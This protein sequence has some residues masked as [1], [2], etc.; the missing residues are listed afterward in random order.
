MPHP[1]ALDNNTIWYSPTQ[2][3][4]PDFYANLAFGYEGVGRVRYDLTD[5][6]DGLP[7]INLAGYTVQDYYDHVAGDGNVAITGTFQGWVTVPHSEGYYGA[8]QCSG[9]DNDGGVGRV[10]QVAVD[11]LKVFSETNPSYWADTSPDAFWKRYDANDDG[12]VDA[13]WVVHAGMGQESG[14][15]QQGEYAIWSHSWAL[16]AQGFYAGAIPGVKVYEG[17]VL[18]TTD[19]IYVDPY[20]VQPENLDLGV[21]VEEFGHNFFGLPDLYTTDAQNSVGLLVRDVGRLLG[22]LDRRRDAGRHAALVPHERLVRRRLVQL[23]GADAHPFVP[24]CRSHGR[25]RPARE[26]TPGCGQGPAHQPPVHPR[27]RDQP[28][29]HRQGSLE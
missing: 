2:T 21:L 27:D 22:R 25:H 9:A 16:S 5:P 10:G 20:T 3:A 1:S 13:F 18:T 6:V 8:P 4:D 19:D 12:F 15:G 24:G 7:G 17:D 28:R 14:G 26:D 23:A 11:A 29:R